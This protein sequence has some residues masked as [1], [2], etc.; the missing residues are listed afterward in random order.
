MRNKMG[1]TAQEVV[2]EKFVKQFG[3]DALEDAEQRRRFGHEWCQDRDFKF[4][5]G[6]AE[7]PGIS[8]MVLW[9]CE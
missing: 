6:G 1:T 5:F 9:S 8:N 2:E 3:R 4:T 7:E